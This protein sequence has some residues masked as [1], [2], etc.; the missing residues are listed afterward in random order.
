MPIDADADVGGA[1][2]VGV[3]VEMGLVIVVAAGIGGI[4][5]L[6]LVIG[7]CGSWVILRE[8]MS[9]PP[10]EGTCGGYYTLSRA[11][12]VTGYV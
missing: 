1:V 11:L 6:V 5:I 8:E 12:G 10:C 3:G 4:V 9:L 7:D 2:A